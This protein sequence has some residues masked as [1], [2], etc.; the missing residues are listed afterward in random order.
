MEVTDWEAQMMDV[1]RILLSMKSLLS[2]S[3]DAEEIVGLLYPDF[4][5]WS[6]DADEIAY[7]K[8]I[9]SIK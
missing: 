8:N 2:V 7:A 1:R 3:S 5:K 9:W 6:W 4:E